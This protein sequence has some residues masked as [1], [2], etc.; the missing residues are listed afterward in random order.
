MPF[1]INVPQ[2]NRTHEDLPAVFI[3]VENEAL[4]LAVGITLP[5]DQQHCTPLVMACS[6]R[7]LLPPLVP[8]CRISIFASFRDGFLKSTL[9][10]IIVDNPAEADPTGCCLCYITLSPQK[11]SQK[12]T[13]VQS[14][15]HLPVLHWIIV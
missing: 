7:R 5:G 9:G 6:C 8:E 3:L 15:L 13:P 11:I 2:E 4:I 12:N 1:F 10:P 14:S